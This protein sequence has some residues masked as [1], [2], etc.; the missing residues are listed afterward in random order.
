MAPLSNIW[1]PQKGAG[2]ASTPDGRFKGRV[3]R[4][5]DTLAAEGEL[6]GEPVELAL[7]GWGAAAGS[8]SRS[9][10]QRASQAGS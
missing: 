7:T 10:G 2:G 4:A 8:H 1:G 3:R 9:D 5:M 6:R